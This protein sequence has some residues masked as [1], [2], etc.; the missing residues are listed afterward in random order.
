MQKRNIKL[1]VA[2]IKME[3]EIKQAIIHMGIYAEPLLVEM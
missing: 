1:G 3:K 2:D